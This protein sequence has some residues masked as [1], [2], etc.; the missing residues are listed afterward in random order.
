MEQ[1]K[2]Q[3]APLICTKE[4][5][6]EQNL[7]RKI[8]QICFG[9]Q[10]PQEI[11][12]C[13]VLQV[14]E[15]SLYKMPERVPHP[16][17]VLDRR[18]GVSNKN[19]VCET[20][21]Q[22]LADC[23]GHFGYIR[24][25]LPVFHIG[26][27]KNTVQI[28]QCICK[29]CSRVLLPEEERRE[30]LTDALQ[31]N[32]QLRPHLHRLADDLHPLRVRALFEAIPDTDLDLLDIQGRPEDLIVTHIAVP[33]VAIRPSVEMDGASNEDDITVKLMQIIDVN[34]VLRQG[35]EKGLPIGNLMEN[36]DFLQ[37][38][39]AMLIN[40]DLP[41]LPA[42][43]Q[44]PG[45]P[46]RGFV[47][48][49]KG[50]QGR[51]RGNLSGKRVD[52]S[53]RTVISP[54]PN[55][56]IYQVALSVD[57]DVKAAR[58]V[59]GRLEKTTLGQV[60]RHIRIV[61]KPGRAGVGALDGMETG[62]G[63]D[64]GG[65]GADGGGGTGAYGGGTGAY[66]GGPRL[67]G[68]AVI[69]IRLD[70]AAIEALQLDVDGHTVKYSILAHPKLKLKDAHVRAV[71]QDK[72]LVYP[73]DA[74]RQGLLFCLENLLGQL[75]KGEVLGITRFGIAKMKDSVLHTASFEKT[76]DHLFD[77][78]IHGR[79]DDVVGVSESIIMGIP[80]PTGTGLFKIR[81]NV[82]GQVG[83]LFERP[84]PLLAYGGEGAGGG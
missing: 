27:F 69:S 8:Q 42:Q 31:Y 66:G 41:G 7:P 56:Q 72:V 30:T 39:A 21:G 54:D 79:V 25:E 1:K 16:N 45:R 78:A 15:R 22:K 71:A 83:R 63:G 62:G 52:F 5:Y 6:R 81:H 12:K 11:V 48:R 76:S 77:A 2:E 23:A 37:V 75:P 58:L 29:S 36:W 38:Q 19:Y 47:Q 32:D 40:S 10:T 74:S 13:G 9:L 44:M 53:G 82:V 35:L 46:L 20:C 4:P 18:L 61:L 34:N 57:N 28:L 14:Y 59:K 33:P 55:L 49:L 65:G 70:M 64:G 43:F 73:P 80:M 60:A 50:K 26:Y 3:A 17:G 84:L 67:H 24:L 51:F 68:E